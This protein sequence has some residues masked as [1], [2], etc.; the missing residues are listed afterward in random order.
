MI[1][2]EIV[3]KEVEVSS[4]AELWQYLYGILVLAGEGEVLHEYSGS[5]A[6][7]LLW[8]SAHRKATHGRLII[9]HMQV[10]ICISFLPICDQRPKI[11][12]FSILIGCSYISDASANA[13]FTKEKFGWKIFTIWVRDFWPVF[14]IRDILVP[15]RIRIQFR[16]LFFSSVTFK[17][18]TK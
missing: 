3:W 8:W 12:C 4:V 14:R 2:E 11:S 6:A 17:N 9:S 18:P 7:A 1:W 13:F 16:I 15:V 5:A 10:E